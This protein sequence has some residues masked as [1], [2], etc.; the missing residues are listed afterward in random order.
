MQTMR[1]LDTASTSNEELFVT[2]C[3]FLGKNSVLFVSN[4]DEFQRVKYV[5]TKYYPT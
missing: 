3:F 4:R 2:H 1:S 5:L